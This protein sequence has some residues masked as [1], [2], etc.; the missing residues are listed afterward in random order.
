M[1]A[2]IDIECKIFKPARSTFIEVLR[3]IVGGGTVMNP[4]VVTQLTKRSREEPMQRLTRRE[5]V[6][7]LRAEGT[8]QRG[9]AGALSSPRRR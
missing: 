1:L 3:N 7:E 9:F 6:L 5:R 4:D 2:D 8:A